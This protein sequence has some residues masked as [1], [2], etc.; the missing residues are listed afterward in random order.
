MAQ[1]RKLGLR[2]WSDDYLHW[3]LGERVAIKTVTL[4][5]M[6]P[7]KVPELLT[8]TNLLL[9]PGGNTYQVLRGIDRYKELIREAIAEGLPY[10][11]KAQAVLLRVKLL[12]LLH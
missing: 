9:V 4:G 1:Y 10:V 12:S 6:D 2:K 7:A 8:N 5:D 3:S 11:G